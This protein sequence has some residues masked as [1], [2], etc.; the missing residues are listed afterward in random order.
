MPF[1]PSPMDE[2]FAPARWPAPDYEKTAEVSIATLPTDIIV[3][4]LVI[5]DES[6][7][8]WLSVAGPD[9]PASHAA[10]LMIADVLRQGLSD[11][12][13]ARETYTK[14]RDTII[15]EAPEIVELPALMA[16]LRKLWGMD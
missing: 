5:Q 9:M 11:N 4:H 13:S 8:A 10:R 12:L 15:F 6:K 3:G 2:T 1:R 16:Q 7:L 14:A